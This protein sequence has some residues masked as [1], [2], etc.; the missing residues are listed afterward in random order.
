MLFYGG[1]IYGW[2]AL[3]FVLKADGYYSNLCKNETI[4]NLE[5]DK[6]VNV[7]MDTVPPTCSEQDA[8]LNLVFTAAAFSLSVSLILT[9]ALFDYFGTRFTRL[10]LQ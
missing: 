2:A 8:M 9:G 3:V 6:D 1:P 10:F 5:A 7:T 4:D